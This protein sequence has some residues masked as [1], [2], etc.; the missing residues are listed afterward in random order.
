MADWY[1]SHN[2]SPETV[3]D[4]EYRDWLAENVGSEEAERFW[5]GNEDVTFLGDVEEYYGRTS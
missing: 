1:R 4:E 2:V 5:F 3:S